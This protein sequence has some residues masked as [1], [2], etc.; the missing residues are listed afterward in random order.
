MLNWQI[1]Y[2]TP[3][4]PGTGGKLRV[5]I[6]DFIVEEVPAY[7]PC[8]TGEHTFFGVE[9]RD[10]STLALIHQL[11]QALGV[12]ERDIS[13][14]GLKD[15]R[16]VARQTFSVQWVPPEK[17]MTLTLDKARILWAKRHT[18]KLRSGHLR[19]NRFTL[20]IRD[21]APD[22]GARTSA[23]AGQLLARGVP[24]GYGRQR[25]GN[26][27]NNHEMGLLLLRNDR[28][29]LRTHGIHH[30]SYKMRQ[31]LISAVQSA[32]FNALLAARIEQ[33]LLDDVLPGDVARKEDTG[34]IFI[35]EDA[36]AERPRVKAWEISATGPIYGYKMLAAQ[37]EA[38]ALE[39]RILEEA[40]IALADFR[41]FQ[42]K[43][44]RRPLRYYPEGLSWQMEGADTL[45]LS[46][47]AP[48]GA[49]AT[50]LLR[51]LMKT[52]VTLEVEDEIDEGA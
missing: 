32:L 26:R 48:K 14:A 24:N 16:A 10:I 31:F 13:C 30:L 42:A 2:L 22:A 37:A 52:E 3:D 25:F 36:E 39:A 45:T 29:A 49:Y 41:P 44:S 4:L 5:E 46:F 50:S 12:A 7:E 6:D 47:F 27:G 17:L 43:G 18:N 38:G 23:I 20:R 34:G 1:P 40:S 35:V 15:A 51:E 19:G 11:A 33:G 28:A 9:K 21:V 8:G